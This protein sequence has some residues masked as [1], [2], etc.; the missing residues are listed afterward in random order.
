MLADNSEMRF[1]LLVALAVAAFGCASTPA[2]TE[3]TASA[4][5]D[6]ASAAPVEPADDD[7]APRPLEVKGKLGDREY[8]PAIALGVGTFKRDG[9]LHMVLELYES[10][11]DCKAN[12][13]K[14]QAKDGERQLRVGIPWEQGA[15]LDLAAPP[16]DLQFNPNKMTE[17]DGK[18]WLDVADW[19]APFGAIWVF[20]APTKAGEKG[21]IRL[22][23]RAGNVRLKGDVPVLLCNEAS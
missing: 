16:P 10:E 18:H 12:K 2:S 15:K 11:R 22:R 23:V 8:K 1:S 19:K 3:P 17:W 7:P 6:E 9:R 20:E 4:S 14:V 13:G 21:R 5:L